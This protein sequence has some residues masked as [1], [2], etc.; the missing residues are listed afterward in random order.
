MDCNIHEFFLSDQYLKKL[1]K[2]KK[3]LLTRTE[4][5]VNISLALSE[6][7]TLGEVSKWS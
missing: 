3:K 7:A 4:V 5:F 2:I 6:S 1:K